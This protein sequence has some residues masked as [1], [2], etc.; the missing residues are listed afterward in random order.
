MTGFSP[1]TN[2]L[3]KHLHICKPNKHFDVFLVG[4]KKASRTKDYD[5]G[6]L[7]FKCAVNMTIL[8]SMLV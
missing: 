6:T 3:M 7:I 8:I 4:N 5:R 2:T 1:G